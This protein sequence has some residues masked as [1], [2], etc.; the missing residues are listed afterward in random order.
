MPTQRS[1]YRLNRKPLER[2]GRMSLVYYRCTH[3]E[4]RVPMKQVILHV[5]GMADRPREEV[6]GRAPLHAATPPPRDRRVQGGE[7]GL[8]PGPPES[9]R[10][11]SGLLGTTI[12]GY[13]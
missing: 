1:A 4:R 6:D 3:H 12:L 8:R 13:D 11:G 2:R 7:S 10:Q 9:V 5:D